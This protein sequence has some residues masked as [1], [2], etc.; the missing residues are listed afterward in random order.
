MKHALRR[1]A[2]LGCA[3]VTVILGG[4]SSIMTHTGPHQGYYPGTRNDVRMIKD[5]DTG[6]VMTPF[7][8]LDLPFS[9]V[10]DTLLLPYDIYRAGKTE[11]GDS[12]RERIRHGAPTEGEPTGPGTPT[13]SEE[14][15]QQRSD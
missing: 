8:A 4:C 2:L 14:Q 9:A 5:K 15:P 3:G 13:H 12:P 10:L 1:A 7:L 11:V 6:W